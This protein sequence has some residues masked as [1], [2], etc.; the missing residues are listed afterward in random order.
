MTGPHNKGHDLSTVPLETVEAREGI[1]DTVCT[2]HIGN[3]AEEAVPVISNLAHVYT[4]AQI[5]ATLAHVA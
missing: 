4:L 3:L 5:N 2:E 1:L